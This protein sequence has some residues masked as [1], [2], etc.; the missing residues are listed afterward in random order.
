MALH[1]KVLPPTIKVDKP[2][3]KLNI[4]ESPFYINATLRPWV[5]DSSHD[6][7]ASVSSFGFGGSN[8]HLTLEEYKGEHRPGRFRTQDSELVTLSAESSSA[9]AGL[10]AGLPSEGPGLL[11]WMAHWSQ[12]EFNAKHAA[13]VAIV[14]E[15]DDDL[16]AKLATA[17]KHIETKGSEPLNAPNGIYYGTGEAEGAV[18]LLFPGQGSQY[19]HMGRDLAVHYERA[20]SAWDL[21]AD[22]ELDASTLHDV[23]FPRHSF[24][25][26]AEKAQAAEL[27][28]TH[29]AQPATARSAYRSLD[30]RDGLEFDATG[31]HSY[32]EVTALHAA[33]AFDAMTML[34]VARKRG[35]L[36]TDAAK[37]PGSMTA[38]RATV[39]EVH[40]PR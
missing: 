39:D 3:P 23:V 12:G 21:A 34:Q 15:S 24:A 1:H 27:V 38:V 30:L 28:K 37:T 20:L 5:R 26:G 11:P 31:G 32:G 13:R 36:M 22:L 4:E 29:W 40:G 14:A 18:G 25:D 19:L 16:R 8:F 17:K 9:L 2:N 33:G 7:R 35:V 6:R 10:I